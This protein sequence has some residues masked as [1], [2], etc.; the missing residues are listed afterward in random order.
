MKRLFPVLLW[1]FF[2]VS[3]RGQDEF[4]KA[5]RRRNKA[6]AEAAYRQN[7]ETHGASPD[8]LVLPGLLADRGAKRVTVWGEATGTEGGTTAEFFL[9]GA[10]SGHGYEA[11]AVSF[12][13]AGDVQKGLEFIG[14]KPGRSVDY[15]NLQF[16]PKGERVIMSIQPQHESWT[17]GTMRVE[18]M[19]K[20]VNSGKPMPRTGLV[21]TGSP[22]VPSE[23]DP[24]TQ[25]HAADKFE[26]NSLA[27][28]YN[29]PQTVLDVPR[30]APQNDVYNSL[31]V[32]PDYALP[33]GAPLRIVFEPEYKDDRRRVMDLAL[34]TVVKD[35]SRGEQL[36]DVL[37][38][39]RCLNA[40]G[41]NPEQG[42]LDAKGM[43]EK[44]R[45]CVD[46]GRDPFVA[47]KPADALSL[48]VVTDLARI[49][50][51]LEGEK[52]IRVEP[53]GKHGIYYQAFTSEEKF[54]VRNRRPGEAWE[55]HIRD[56]GAK[57]S[58]LTA[59]LVKIKLTWDDTG[60]IGAEATDIPLAG[61]E[62]L[63]K[64]LAKHGPGL[65]VILVF[66]DATVTYG[67]LLSYLTPRVLSTHGT[68]HVYL[69]DVGE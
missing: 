6:A 4:D 18:D 66:T 11:L 27:S 23:T 26:P 12:A 13:K 68:I 59:K 53:P 5:A 50:G 58:R 15:A 63:P 42:G 16:W 24:T 43:I 20:D 2:A 51:A 69:G 35:G 57:N 65:P 30:K 62:E 33:G 7:L 10:T 47:L 49:L 39:L 17:N 29:E 38:N 67:G 14:M 54:R 41:D 40:G 3:A 44:L 19:M 36:G 61:P 8:M 64:A 9:I 52:G 46:S 45:D 37:F 55:L 31:S 21:F 22:L 34:E 25:I 1:L 48:R 28:N 56:C 60:G 32:N